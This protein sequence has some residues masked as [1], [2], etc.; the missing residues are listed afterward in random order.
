MHVPKKSYF[1]AKRKKV[2]EFQ[3]K[4]WHMIRM[5][6]VNVKDEEIPKN[7][8]F[9]L[10]GNGKEEKISE[11]YRDPPKAT[12]QAKQLPTSHCHP[13]ATCGENENQLHL[14]LAK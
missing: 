3:Q 14:K 2:F 11:H 5:T 1:W 4:Q 12:T 6:T 7:L 13:H 10:R 8:Q 9:H